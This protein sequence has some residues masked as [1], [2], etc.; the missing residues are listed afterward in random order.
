MTD[1]IE[2]V[3]R[4]VRCSKWLQANWRLG[5]WIGFWGALNIAVTLLK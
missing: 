4:W 2:D 5:W 3:K 1:K